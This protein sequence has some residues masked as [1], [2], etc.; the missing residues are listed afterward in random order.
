V[1]D[2]EQEDMKNAEIAG[3]TNR[4][5]IITF[6]EMMIEIR[7][8]LWNLACSDAGEDGEDVDEAQRVQDNLGEDNKT[9]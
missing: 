2:Q 1:V 7:Y 3:L 9:G 5:P 8:S 6:D 4:E